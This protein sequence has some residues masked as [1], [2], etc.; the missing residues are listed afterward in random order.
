MSSDD[1][2]IDL[3]DIISE[4][5]EPSQPIIVEQPQELDF[6][7]NL[8]GLTDDKTRNT[9]TPIQSSSLTDEIEIDMSDILTQDILDNL[10]FESPTIK[11]NSDVIEIDL[12]DNT[13]EVYSAKVDERRLCG[14]RR[15]KDN[16]AYTHDE[17]VYLAVE[18][19]VFDK[20]TASR[21]TMETLCKSLKIPFT[22]P[23]MA[24]SGTIIFDDF[25]G[26]LKMKKSEI[27]QANLQLLINKG[28][29]LEMANRTK[30]EDLCNI[31]Y[32]EES[33]FTVPED[34]DE[35]SCR[36][37]DIPTLIRIATILKIDV[38]RA[39][40]L[41]DYC[42]IISTY[43]K[44][45]KMNFNTDLSNSWDASTEDYKCLIP[46]AK[47]L[48]LQEH[49]KRVVRHI[50][51]HR[52]L[53]VIHATGSGKTLTAVT[54]INCMLAKYPNIK[55]LVVTP[56][57]L[58]DNFKK[59]LIQFGIAI[60][61]PDFESRVDIKGYDE[62]VNAQ[63]RKNQVDC[64]NTFLIIDEAHNFRTDPNI[65]NTRIEKGS[66][67]YIMLK[68]A[69]Q[70]FKVL[71]L[72]ATP[73]VNYTYDLRN[74]LAMVNGIDPVNIESRAEFMKSVKTDDQLFEK[75]HCK[76]SYYETPKENFPERIDIPLDEIRL[77]MTQEYY[78][79]YMQIERRVA[80]PILLEGITLSNINQ[81]HFYHSLRMAINA[82]DKEESPK[83]NW[84]ID[85]IIK[86][87][88]E[89][90][91]SIVYSN[92]K[93]AGMNLLRKRLDELQIPNLFKL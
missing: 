60:N 63:K 56:L 8:R 84:I 54:A 9:E 5:G 3:S 2:E 17:L 7:I 57:S 12:S 31:I 26:C 42:K 52:G 10:Q 67:T 48:I 74:L 20:K 51:T 32:Q 27:V 24:G 90:R 69:S 91:K 50:L 83:V 36:L 11:E 34:F 43:Y 81:N 44:R 55:V 73:V 87:A 39:K 49:Q 59:G 18:N 29:S 80:S 15:T 13:T 30:K 40:F 58:I 70:A 66:K 65:K 89:G 1:I 4:S 72:S 28:I 62:F 82:L 61:N 23:K 78:D 88:Q 6:D 46:L 79:K 19:G 93:T 16:N 71:L 25:G 38:T 64:Q 14:P 85:Y 47:D 92:F 45:K 21:L 68:C 76:V 33:P 35:A 53:M 77:Y 75:L 22:S 86:E 37:Y 41:K